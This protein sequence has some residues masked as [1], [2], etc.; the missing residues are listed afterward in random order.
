MTDAPKSHKE[1]VLDALLMANRT[2]S[3][4]AAGLERDV[5][6]TCLIQAQMHTDA[7]VEKVDGRKHRKKPEGVAP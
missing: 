1:L 2:A 5:L 7:I 4:M 6:L 3:G